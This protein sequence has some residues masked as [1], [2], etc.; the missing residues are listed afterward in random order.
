MAIDQWATARAYFPANPP[1]G[2]NTDDQARVMS[3][4]MYENMYWSEPTVFKIVARSDDASPIFLP[5][6]RSIIEACA[7]FLAVDWDFLVH[8]KVGTPE[9]R[10]T[11]KALMTSIFKR[12]EVYA[13]FASQKRNCLIRG[14]ALWHITADDTKDPGERIS[15]HELHPGEYFPIFDEDNPDKI[16]GCYIVDDT[17]DPRDDTKTLSRRQGYRKDPVTGL[18]TSTLELYELAKWDDRVK[19]D[20]ATKVQ[21]VRPPIVLPA[22]IKTIPVYHIRNFRNSSIWG[23]SELRGVETI[24]AGMNQAVSDQDLAIS[25]QGMGVY[26]TDAGPPKNLDGTDGQFRMGPGEVVEVPTGTNFGRVSGITGAL[27]GI[28]HMNFLMGAATEALGV[29]DVARGKVD[30]TIAES[31]ISLYLQMGPLL[32]KNAEKEQEMLG[33]Y[34]HMLYDLVNQ[35]L[36]AYE[37]LPDSTVVEVASVVGD[38]LPQNRDAQIAEILTL[39]TS[40]PPLITIGMAQAKLEALGYEFPANAEDQVMIEAKAISDARAMTDPYSSRYKDE[41]ENEEPVGSGVAPLPTQT[42][43]GAPPLAG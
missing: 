8:P 39:V 1:A 25:M 12:E 4:D 34:D 10:D 24:M 40:I 18:I 21:D 20:D 19:A 42:T 41:I 15:M 2:L 28:E 26:W 30:I 13:K 23:S 37:G 29:P 16:V 31:G 36:V 6:A 3:Y 38:P 17:P 5:S 22:A 11:V 33:K 35:W 32:A 14:E 43:P 27:P 9:D 7:R